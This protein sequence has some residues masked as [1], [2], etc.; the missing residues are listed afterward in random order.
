MPEP[1]PRATTAQESAATTTIINAIALRRFIRSSLSPLI[2]LT[3]FPSPRPFLSGEREDDV[4]YHPA[5]ELPDRDVGSHGRRFSRP[6]QAD[7]H[8]LRGPGVRQHRPV[9]R[10]RGREH[11]R[12][13][14][15]GNQYVVGPARGRGCARHG[16]GELAPVAAHGPLGATT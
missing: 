10:A 8:A 14:H 6:D 9:D 1:A 3:S 2:A 16:A 4:V 5:G 7:G 12:R 15:H 13:E 11:P